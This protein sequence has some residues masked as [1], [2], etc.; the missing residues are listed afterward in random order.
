MEGERL[1]LPEHVHSRPERRK[2]VLLAIALTLGVVAIGVAQFMVTLGEGAILGVNDE[3]RLLQPELLP[4]STS[5]APSAEDV[6]AF[7]EQLQVIYQTNH[8]P[9]VSPP[10]EPSVTLPPTL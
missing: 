1:H 9:E 7:Q 2:R 3:L 5:Q 4:L 6:Q 8:A 10:V